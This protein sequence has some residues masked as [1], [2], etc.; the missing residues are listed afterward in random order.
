MRS[1]DIPPRGFPACWANF[2]LESKT[3]ATEQGKLFETKDMLRRHPSLQEG[4]C[5][6]PAGYDDSGDALRVDG[7]R[8]ASEG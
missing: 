7:D 2:L 3:E 6:C 1:I 5:T 4:A 8:F